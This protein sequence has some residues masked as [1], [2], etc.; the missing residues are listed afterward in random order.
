MPATKPASKAPAR[1]ATSKSAS[2]PASKAATRTTARGNASRKPATKNAASRNA[3]G[4]RPR[5]VNRPAKRAVK[6][7]PAVAAVVPAQVT[8]RVATVPTQWQPA[9]AQATPYAPQPAAWQPAANPIYGVPVKV[10]PHCKAQAQMAGPRCPHCHKKYA[11][12]KRTVL[13][14]FLGAFAA[15]IAV[16]VLMVVALGSAAN[17]AVKQLNAEQAKHAIAPTTYSK[18]KI[19]ATKAAVLRAVR[20]ATP[21]NTQ[22]FESAG[23]LSATDI[24]SSCVYFNKQGGSFGDIYQFCFDG[25]KLATKSSY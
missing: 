7:A 19:G 23:V 2:Q 3:P 8:H 6:T 18:I 4:P 17:Q 16:I 1:K 11:K 10:C 9:A 20:P 14:V 15:L 5:A 22:E 24:K 25:N 13:K 12:K 21:E